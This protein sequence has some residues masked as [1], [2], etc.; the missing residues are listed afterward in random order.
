MSVYRHGLE[1]FCGNLRSSIF[2]VA[3]LKI[4]PV[5]RNGF[6]S[7][8]CAFTL[9]EKWSNNSTILFPPRPSCSPRN[10]TWVVLLAWDSAAV[11]E[12][13]MVTKRAS[14]KVSLHLR[15]VN[16]NWKENRNGFNLQHV[17]DMAVVRENEGYQAIWS[18]SVLLWRC[19]CVW[20][21]Q[22]LVFRQIRS[23]TIW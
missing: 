18:L 6:E 8:I 20:N 17:V 12:K 4:I 5:K 7:N 9:Q 13:S 19:V 21:I 14:P 1:K 15:F 2:N 11:N 22:N 3:I 10:D 16:C 23:Y